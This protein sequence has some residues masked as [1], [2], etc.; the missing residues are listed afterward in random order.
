MEELRLPL[1]ILG[2]FAIVAV[3]A[4]G[5]W[6]IRKNAIRKA[7]RAAALNAVRESNER[8]AKQHQQ[9]E[10]GFDDLGLG[11]VRVVTSKTEPQLSEEPQVSIESDS[12]QPSPVSL[13]ESAE[14]RDTKPNDEPQMSSAPDWM[15]DDIPEPP[16]SLLRSS[17]PKME[18]EEP[19][20]ATE[21]EAQS[22]AKPTLA[23]KARKLVSREK[24][25]KSKARK[26]PKVAEDQLKIDFDDEQPAAPAPTQ[27]A[28]TQAEPAEQPEQQVL[29][30]NV[31]MPEEKTMTGAAL[32]PVLLTLGFKFGAQDI[33][34]RHVNSNGKGPVLF[35]LANMFK[36]GVFDVDNMENFTTRGV[37]LFMILPIEGDPHQVFNMMHNAARKIADEFGAQILDGRRS[38]LTK[39]G[40]QQYTE[41]IRESE[42]RRML[43]R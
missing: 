25:A 2:I 21:T 34:H 14:T 27:N 7:T 18:V 11:P 29:V 16:S 20:V 35:S 26:E 38:V 30:L 42:R 43:K 15:G 37:S 8:S 41:K 31:K 9:D 39:Q 5:L 24:P 10:E 36:P 23:D 33:F 28:A 32:L 22:E 12:V 40:L 19:A 3:T 1:L 13:A 4:H 17:E 6:T